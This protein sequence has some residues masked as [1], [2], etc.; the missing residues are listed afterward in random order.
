[1][2]NSYAEYKKYIQRDAIANYRTNCKP[3][4]WGDYNWKF[5][6][7]LRRKEYY[8]NL[9]S[10]IK[11]I[12]FCPMILLNKHLFQKYSL[13]CGYTICAGGEDWKRIIF[14]A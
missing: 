3:R 10:S 9:N 5:I 2:I 12:L 11:K 1:M 6:L 8:E 7:A 13:K 4:F 14:T